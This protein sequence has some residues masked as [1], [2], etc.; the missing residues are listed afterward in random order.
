MRPL[1]L[2]AHSQKAMTSAVIGTLVGKKKLSI[3]LGLQIKKHVL[4]NAPTVTDVLSHQTRMST[5]NYY[6][7]PDNENLISVKN[8]MK[9]ISDQ[10]PI[11]SFLIP[12][13]YNR[14]SAMNSQGIALTGPRVRV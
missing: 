9:F 13:G 5:G 6:L 2:A 11:N 10:E 7:G 12:F 4:R 8:S 1:L 3:L 14:P